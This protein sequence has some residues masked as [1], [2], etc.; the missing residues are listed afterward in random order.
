MEGTLRE[1]I[2]DSKSLRWHD[3]IYVEPGPLTLETRFALQTEQGQNMGDLRSLHPVADFW[4][5]LK[6]WSEWRAGRQPN[7]EQAL[8]AIA[9]YDK[10]DAFIGTDLE[11]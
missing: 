5:I 8:R 6:A 3:W 2:A 7:E 9:Y 1:L 11:P 4:D 10:R